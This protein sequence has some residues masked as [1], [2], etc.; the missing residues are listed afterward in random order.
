MA[1][2]QR[3]Q[4]NPVRLNRGRIRPMDD[5]LVRSY[6]RWRAVERAT[7]D[8]GRDDDADAAFGTMFRD[9]VRE[10]PVSL[11]FTARALQAVAAAAERDAQRVRRTRKVLVPVGFA[12]AA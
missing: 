9:A 11:D 8:I 1:R 12:A 5:E 4:R 3:R 7:E 6:N 2:L 10:Q